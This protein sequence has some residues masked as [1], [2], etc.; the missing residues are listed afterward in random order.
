MPQLYI[1]LMEVEAVDRNSFNWVIGG[2][3]SVISF[4][5]GWKI[6]DSQRLMKVEK[7]IAANIEGDKN[8]DSQIIRI[9]GEVKKMG[10]TVEQMKLVVAEQKQM[11][12][13]FI[14]KVDKVL[15]ALG[16]E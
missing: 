8:R 10:Q 9:E 16:E 7:L 14:I 5:F 13:E 11:N 1:T 2:V 3:S 15:R 6:R 12:N 4:L